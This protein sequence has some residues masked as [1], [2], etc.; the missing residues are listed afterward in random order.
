[1]ILN[2]LSLAGQSQQRLMVVLAASAREAVRVHQRRGN[3]H[4]ET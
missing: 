3:G 1:M 2:G 4:G